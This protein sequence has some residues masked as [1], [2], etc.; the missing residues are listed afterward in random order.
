MKYIIQVADIHIKQNRL[1]TEYKEVLNNFINDIKPFVEK[2]KNE[3]AIL[4]AGDLVD[5]FTNI[6]N[7]LEILL[8]WFLKSLDDI[9]PVLI[10]AGN[11]DLTRSNLTKMDTLTPLFTLIDFKQTTYLD[12]VTEYKSGCIELDDN[13]VLALYSIFDDYKR[14]N[15][16]QASDQGKKIIGLCHGPVIGTKTD[17]GFTMDKGIKSDIFNDCDIVLLGDIHKQQLFE[18][19][20]GVPMYYCGSL[21]QQSKS[22]TTTK[23]GWSVIDLST[24]E[25]I[26]HEV[27]NPYKTYN[28]EINSIDDIENDLEIWKNKGQ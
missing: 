12:M 10:M 26:H 20:E 5:N 19:S 15:I 18:N 23:H 2:N 13:I 22:E 21:I 1:H 3:V 14:P 7:E 11:H 28:F 24:F 16:E 8:A 17:I 25:I 4:I 9:C 6:T 27:E